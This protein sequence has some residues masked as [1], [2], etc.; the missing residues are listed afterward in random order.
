VCADADAPGRTMLGAEQKRAL[1]A[2]LTGSDATWRV[3]ANQNMM[4]SMVVGDA[5]ERAF[6]DCWDDYGAER[7]EVLS[8]LAAAGR[9]LVLVTGD[10]HD[11]FAGELWDTG[12]AATG[13]RRAGVEFVV[14]SVTTINTGDLRGE[15]AAR[16]D[17]H[18][19]LDRNAHLRLADQVQHGYGVLT[20]S[21]AEAAFAYRR[22]DKTVPHA[23]VSTPY[24][25]RVERGSAQLSREDRR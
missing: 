24:T 2:A 19:R 14:P 22:V 15:D 18:N 10:D 11:T 16:T 9:D 4:M 20:L 17:E 21:R 6:Y 7:T 13:T 12:S 5:G 8:T 23:A 1:L 3:L 25:L